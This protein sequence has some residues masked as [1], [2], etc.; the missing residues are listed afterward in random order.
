[1]GGNVGIGLTNP[2]FPLQIRGT[3]T[4]AMLIQTTTTSD[5]ILVYGNNGGTSAQG[6][7][8]MPIRVGSTE[9]LVGGISWS[10]SAMQYNGTSDYR[11]KSN[12]IFV[13]SQLSKLRELMVK[14]FNIFDSTK[15][16]V[17]FIAHE[18]QEYY[19]NIVTGKKN[20]V[21]AH[22]K[23]ELQQVN[24]QG[25]IPY[26]V[27]GIQELD[28]QTTHLAA[29]NT[30]LKSTIAAQASAIA[31]QTSSIASLEARLAALESK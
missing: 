29:E 16:E 10:G 28:E 18:L 24:L 19:P 31:V 9:T 1:M 2:T 7:Y 25:L 23:P 20:A 6:I 21:D 26:M 8:V 27:K 15:R 4:T 22:G 3:G 13:G 11:V 12:I 14:E 30:E 5:M 17:G